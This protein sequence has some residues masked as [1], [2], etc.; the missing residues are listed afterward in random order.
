MDSTSPLVSIVIPTYNQ[1]HPFLIECIEGAQSQTYANFEIIISDNH[2]TNGASEIIAEYAKNDKRIKA[3]KP[4]NHLDIV[5][6][7]LFAVD[8]AVGKYFCIISSDDILLPTCVEELVT[9][10]ENNPNVVFAH[11]EA[12]HFTPDGKETLEWKHFNQ[13][14]G[15]YSFEDGLDKFI[16]HRYT[17]MAGPLIRN[18]IFKKLETESDRSKYSHNITYSYDTYL[19]FRMLELGNVGY[20]GHA[21]A[22]IRVEN[23]TRAR[24]NTH[25]LQDFVYTYSWL[26]QSSLMKRIPNATNRV[27]RIKSNLGFSYLKILIYKR[28]QNIVSDQEYSNLLKF[29]DKLI[30]PKYLIKKSII[31]IIL[32]FPTL[33]L[34]LFRRKV[35]AQNQY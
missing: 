18:D 7:F 28:I 20:I 21:L 27:R 25:L 24:A 3:I 26:E 5:R 17:Y 33:P 14:T 11:G 34:I 12:I 16:N 2:S 9:V 6:S 10:L 32:F 8:N 4:I 15:I 23:D 29:A 31:R 35:K 22:K 1:K 13:K 19:L 30:S